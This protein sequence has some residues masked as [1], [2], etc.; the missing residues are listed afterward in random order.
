MST[1]QRG[2]LISL[3]LLL[4]G[5]VGLG[6]STIHVDSS[7]PWREG[8]A[9]VAGMALLIAAMIAAVVYGPRFLA[10]LAR[11]AAREVL[12]ET[13]EQRARHLAVAAR[14]AR[15]KTFGLIGVLTAAVVYE[16]CFTP[17]ARYSRL[18][19]SIE[20]LEGHQEE[21][22][23]ELVAHGRDLESARFLVVTRL[24]SLKEEARRLQ[25]QTSASKQPTPQLP[26][27]VLR[28]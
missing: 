15:W 4:F 25:P 16:C 9:N 19:S 12:E 7:T 20:G 24:K 3:A 2:V 27:G 11:E 23:A 14:N 5:Y 6:L 8:A 18:R 10:Q 21:A 26:Q 13:P 17:D 22:I 1:N 28:P